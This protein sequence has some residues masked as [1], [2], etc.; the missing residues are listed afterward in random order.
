MDIIYLRDLRIDAVIGIDDWER[1][2]KQTVI[3][4]L[5]MAADIGKAAGSDHIADALNYKSVAR[6]LIGFVEES[7]FKLVETLA[8]R[9]AEIVLSEFNVSW[10]RLTLN[11]KGALRD[12][13]DVG[14]IIERGQKP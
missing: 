7:E 13:R 5:E 8:E 2:M 3:L 1:R 9:I 14:V 12:V 11:K 4:D 10:C 6:R